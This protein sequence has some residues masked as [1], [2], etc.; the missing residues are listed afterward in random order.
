M[1]FTTSTP[2]KLTETALAHANRNNS[3]LYVKLLQLTAFVSRYLIHSMYREAQCYGTGTGFAVIS[4]LC[5]QKKMTC[6]VPVKKYHSLLFFIEFYWKAGKSQ[7]QPPNFKN[8]EPEAQRG[9]VSLKLTKHAAEPSA[10]RAQ[11]PQSQL[12]HPSFRGKPHLRT[13]HSD[14]QEHEA[15]PASLA[16]QLLP[17]KTTRWTSKS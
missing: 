11:S 1:F 16:S 7:G 15:L 13:G 10:G 5:D 14:A 9:E 3:L 6:K 4:W 2:N 12:L 8:E 17:S